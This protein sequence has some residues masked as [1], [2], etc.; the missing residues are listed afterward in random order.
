MSKYRRYYVYK[1]LKINC[2]LGDTKRGKWKRVNF[3]V[4]LYLKIF[5]FIEKIENN[6][7]VYIICPVRNIT[8]EQQKEI[9]EYVKKLEKEGIS[10]HYPPRDVDQSDPLGF[11]ICSAHREALEESDEVHIFWDV[12]SK[13]S[14]FDLGMAFAF[15]KDV[16][17][18]QFYQNDNKG[19]SYLKVIKWCEFLSL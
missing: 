12:N 19:K 6:K 5:G 11:D 3:F 8:Q 9:D 4:W 13:G 16:R 2:D 18:I 15:S 7:R 17:L 1:N 10:V 14:H